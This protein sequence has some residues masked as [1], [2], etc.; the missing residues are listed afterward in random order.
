MNVN[1]LIVGMGQGLGRHLL[2]LKSEYAQVIGI[3][4]GGIDVADD[5]LIQ[6]NCDIKNLD[7]TE[8]AKL[9]DNIELVIYLVSEWAESSK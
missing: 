8:I 2:E 3:S 1:L 9:A 4:R 7:V 6:L 5:K